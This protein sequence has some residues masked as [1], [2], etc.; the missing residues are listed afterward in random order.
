MSSITAI[1][2]D[3]DGV[4]ADTERLHLGAFQ[5]VF[6]SRGWSLDEADYFDR[7]L[8]YDD[9]GL[10]EA[11]AREQR[12]ALERDDLRDLVRAKTE[13]FSR[14]LSSPDILYAGARRA[15]EALA[16]RYRLA[17]ASGALHREIASILGAAGLRD[18]FPVIVGADDVSECKPAPGPYLAAAAGLGVEPAA[19]LAVEDSLAG[20]TAARAAGM[21]TVAVTTTS[22]RTAL[23][24]ADRIV[25]TLADLTPELVAALSSGAL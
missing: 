22:P 6:A 9:D 24:A 25:D 17:I 11:Y 2:F 7:Y 12:L 16:A 4:I 1:V 23:S 21:R 19:C 13:A 8:G 10:V 14:H 20:L 5:E 18:L 15:I 3:F